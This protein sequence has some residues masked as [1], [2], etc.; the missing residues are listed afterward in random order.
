MDREWTG[1]FFEWSLNDFQN[2]QRQIFEEG[3]R[4]FHDIALQVRPSQHIGEGWRTS[5]TKLLDNALIG[6]MLDEEAAITR[7]PSPLDFQ[8]MSMPE[9]PDLQDL[10]YRRVESASRR[11]GLTVGCL[12]DA[13]PT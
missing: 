5:A 8:S 10:D 7:P 4:A 12:P 6:Y 13:R 3:Y 2:R 11:A 1:R 9:L